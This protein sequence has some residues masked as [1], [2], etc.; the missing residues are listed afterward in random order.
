MAEK[1]HFWHMQRQGKLV[2]LVKVERQHSESPTTCMHSKK[3]KKQL[4]LACDIFSTTADGAPN[5]L[6]EGLNTPLLNFSPKIE[7]KIVMLFTILSVSPS[8][9][10]LS[11]T[12]P[13]GLIKILGWSKWLASQIEEIA[14]SCRY[15]QNIFSH[16][17]Y[18]FHIISPS[19]QFTRRHTNTDQQYPLYVCLQSRVAFMIM[20]TWFC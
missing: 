11:N 9:S 16:P 15:F 1:V 5:R 13:L 7:G 10:L 6:E 14:M 12:L 17:K 18:P 20:R 19:L 3:V 4:F 2:F 8:F